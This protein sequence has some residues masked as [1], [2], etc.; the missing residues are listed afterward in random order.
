MA[1]ITNDGW[2]G[3][4]EG[5]RQHFSMARLRA[6]ETRR[7][8]VHSANTGISGHID[9]RGEIIKKLDYDKRGKILAEV[10]LNNNETFYTKYGDIIA[11]IAIFMAIV[12]FLYSFSKKKIV[13]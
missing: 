2:W 5:H 10:R 7:D 9:Q 8:L 13:L 12:L 6:V 11:R 3:N 4:T 1:V